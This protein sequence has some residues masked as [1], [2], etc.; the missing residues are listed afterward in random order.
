MIRIAIVNDVR[1]AAETLRRIVASLSDTEV[2][3]IAENGQESVDKCRADRPDL[4]LMDLIMPVMNGVEATRRIMLESPCP[5]LV[6][7]ATVSGNRNEVFEALGHG[8]LD[9]VNTPVLGRDGSIAGADELLK[10]IRNIVLLRQG[11]APV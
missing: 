7:T 5:I 9:A 2:A 4:V 10:K 8:A 11:K 6:V 3:W 1:M